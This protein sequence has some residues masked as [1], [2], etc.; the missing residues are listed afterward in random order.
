MSD[1]SF[2]PASEG[3]QIVFGAQR[4]GYNSRPVDPSDIQEW[5]SYMKAQGIERVCCL[6]PQSQLKYYEVDLLNTYR[7]EFG[8]DNVCWA[9][10]EDFRLCK[11]AILKEQIL[12]FLKDSDIKGKRVVVHCSGG[13]GRTGHVLAAWLVFKRGFCEQEAVVAVRK[14][15]RNPYE[16]VNR[17]NATKEELDELLQQCR[18]SN[19]A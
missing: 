16:A 8:Q 3:E 17:G 13:S 5:I 6:L 11:T 7:K 15:G 1:F 9:P 4:P 12:P 2:T 14:M 19:V 18:K 10:I